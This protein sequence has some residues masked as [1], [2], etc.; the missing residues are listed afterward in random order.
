MEEFSSSPA[1]P[2]G[3]TKNPQNAQTLLCS[4]KSQDAPTL[5]KNLKRVTK[6][7][8]HLSPTLL[9][10]HALPSCL[11][12]ILLLGPEKHDNMQWCVPK[13]PI[14]LHENI[15]IS[16]PAAVAALTWLSQGNFKTD[17][18]NHLN[19]CVSPNIFHIYTY[20]HMHKWIIG[21]KKNI[22]R[23]LLPTLCIIF[24]MQIKKNFQYLAVAFW[25]T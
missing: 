1:Y 12:H 4:S 7:N 3:F 20:I 17:T 15:I 8:M 6:H 11:S 16:L 22:F 13:L 5:P 23:S 14:Y 18:F 2:K 21:S 25:H 19:T 9:I 24:R 10:W